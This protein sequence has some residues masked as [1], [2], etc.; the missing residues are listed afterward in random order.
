MEDEDEGYEYMGGGGMGG[1]GGGGMGGVG[2]MGGMGGGPSF[3]RRA[4]MEP[5]KVEVRF[6]HDIVSWLWVW[7]ERFAA[8]GLQWNGLAVLRHAAHQGGS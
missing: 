4:A 3:R 7:V 6:S 5:Q 1:M 8:L 2:G